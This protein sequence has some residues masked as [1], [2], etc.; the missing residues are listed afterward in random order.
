MLNGQTYTESGTYSNPGQCITEVLVLTITAAP[1]WYKD[2]DDDGYSDGTSLTQCEEPAGY[3]MSSNLTSIN[4]DCNDNDAAI[5]PEATEVCN[6]IDDNCDSQVDEGFTDT[7]GDGTKDCLDTDDDNDGTLDNNDCAPLDA[8]K[9]RNGSFYADNDVDGYGS[10]SLQNLCYGASNP[11]AY[12]TIAGD[13]N[14]NNASIRPGATEVCGDGID[15]NCNG[16]IDE[17]CVIS[18]V[19]TTFSQGGWATKNNPLTT[20]SFGSKF[21]TGLYIG[22]SGKSIKLTSA[23]AVKSFLP[24]SGTAARLTQNWFN[25]TNKSLKN[26]FAGQLVAMKLNMVYNPG[27]AEATIVSTDAYN[28]WTVQRLFDEANSKI[29]SATAVSSSILTSLSTACEKVNLS[30]HQGA[31]SG[32]VNCSAETLTR[33]NN[34]EMF[35]I[36]TSSAKMQSNAKDVNGLSIEVFGNPSNH[37]FTVKVNSNKILDISMR[38]TDI[39]GRVREVRSGLINGQTV[40]FGSGFE[41]GIYIVELSQENNRVIQKLVKLK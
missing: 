10:G 9:W 17:G 6:G 41:S 4:G 3:K 15:N 1:T 11:T 35:D 19:F 36:M 27:L 24:N 38:V 20:S 12:A 22:V 33:K 5:H 37:A 7:D 26:T 16:Q 30:Y 2:S 21:P 25:P 18:C 13:C 39:N 40:Q 29:S 14:D 28:G 31:V 32:Y 8:T 23:T 34:I